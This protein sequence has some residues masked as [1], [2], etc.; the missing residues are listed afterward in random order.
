MIIIKSI[1]YVSRCY[2][3]VTE[4][5]VIFGFIHSTTICLA[6]FSPSL[7]A[8]S[9]TIYTTLIV[10]TQ[11]YKKA[12]LTKRERATAVNVQKPSKT[13]SVAR[14]RQTTGG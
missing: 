1:G 7:C 6:Q 3:S 11:S 9:S 14:G 4:R 13:K 10:V 8:C 12:Q 5:L 2:E